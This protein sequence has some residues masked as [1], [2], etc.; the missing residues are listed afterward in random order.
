MTGSAAK[1]REGKFA[2]EKQAEPFC[3]NLKTAAWGIGCGCSNY[4]DCGRLSRWLS[5]LKKGG[6]RHLRA[7]YRRQWSESKFSWIN[8]GGTTEASFRPWGTK[9]FILSIEKL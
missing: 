8:K 3:V 4:L 2:R 6:I 1:E 9:V 5:P 7:A